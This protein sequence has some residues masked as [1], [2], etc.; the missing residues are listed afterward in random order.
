MCF[1]SVTE[2]MFHNLPHD[3]EMWGMNCGYPV[4]GEYGKQ[5]ATLH[6][7][8]LLRAVLKLIHVLDKWL[9]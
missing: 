2:Y 6:L 4:S 3:H 8:A 9:S 1:P 5:E 7:A